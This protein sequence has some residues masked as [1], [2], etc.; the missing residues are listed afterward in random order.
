MICKIG[1]TL[2]LVLM[3]LNGLLFIS[4]I[5]VIGDTQAIIAMHDDLAPSSSPLLAN[6]KVI[7]CFITGILYL[8][9]AFGIMK[10][11]PH[12]AIPGFVGFVLFDGLYIF[13]LVIHASIH[14]R[15]WIDFSIFGTISLIIGLFC[16]QYWKNRKSL[17]AI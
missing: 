11:K 12:L 14:P 7:V 13:Q 17:A 3:I 5:Y 1:K 2:I 4:N 6:I 16:L 15:I 9:S 10:K 8:I